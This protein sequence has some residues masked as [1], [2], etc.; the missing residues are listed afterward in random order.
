MCQCKLTPRHS[1]MTRWQVS[2][3]VGAAQVPRH[4]VRWPRHL[5]SRALPPAGHVQEQITAP[6]SQLWQPQ[7]LQLMSPCAH[8][9]AHSVRY[10]WSRP[11][12]W[13]CL[14]AAS[15]WGAAAEGRLGVPVPC[16]ALL[17]E[18][19]NFKAPVP[20]RHHHRPHPTKLQMRQFPQWEQVPKA[21]QYSKP[22]L[23]PRM[24]DRPRYLHTLSFP[25]FAPSTPQ[26]WAP[27]LATLLCPAVRT[28]ATTQLLVT[29]DGGLLC[30]AGL[31]PTHPEPDP[32]CS[33]CF[34]SR[35]N[36]QSLC[37]TLPNPQ[38]PKNKEKKKLRTTPKPTPAP[39]Q[40]CLPLVLGST[41]TGPFGSVLAH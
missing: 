3:W 38:Q 37:R 30:G 14:S 24:P 7:G 22:R 28:A 35:R 9:P 5:V 1:P 16:T 10:G 19:Q 21:L 33:A 6:R 31:T 20:P 41:R 18:Q 39:A 27:A 11:W 13:L 29:A 2:K 36:V 26:I 40:S 34:C 15:P 8:A 32:C 4:N 17:P 12:L 25:P 23:T